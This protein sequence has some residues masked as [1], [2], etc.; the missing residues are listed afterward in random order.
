MVTQFYSI[1]TT[2]LKSSTQQISLYCTTYILNQNEDVLLFIC[3]T[4]KGRII[5]RESCTLASFDN[6]DKLGSVKYQKAKA[7]AKEKENIK[8]NCGHCVCVFSEVIIF[9]KP[10]QS[11]LYYK[12]PC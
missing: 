2:L 10:T 11:I 9:Y 8:L 4:P 1:P 3:F 7:K 5:T 6:E 12:T